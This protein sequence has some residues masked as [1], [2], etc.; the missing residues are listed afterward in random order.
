[1]GLYKYYSI[2][3]DRMGALWT[4]LS[5]RGACILEFGTAGTTRF[6]LNNF[7]KMKGVQNGQLYT[8]HLDENDIAMGDVSRMDKAIDDIVNEGLATNI[9]LM[10]STVSSV[11]GIDLEA[12]CYIY[13]EKYPQINFIYISNDGFKGEWTLGVKNTL[14]T[15]VD[16][17]PKEVNKSE[18]FTYNI[19]GACA[20]DYNYEVDCME[21]DRIMKDGFNGENVCTLTSNTSIKEIENMGAAHLNIVMRSEGEEAAKVLE[22]NFG[23]P[24]VMGR[25]YGLKGTFEWIKKIEKEAKISIKKEFV[26][27]EEKL[28]KEKIDE[29][30]L[31]LKNKS[32][33]L[34]GHYDVVI[35]I[36]DFMR[37]E[38][39]ININNIWCSSPSLSTE[40]VPF[41]EEKI[42]EEIILK[43]DYDILM[44]NGVVTNIGKENCKKLQI[45]LPNLVYS[46]GEQDDNP[47]VGF[48]GALCILNKLIK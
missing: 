25:P 13:R 11:I 30:S 3:S 40:E 19:I 42:W 23:T 28:L 10:S 17:I 9:F 39:G 48:K 33:C 36:R 32:I 44:G 37:D 14:E 20:D 43:G 21:V 34:S 6:A 22:R 16:N 35:G 26:E 5:I 24:Y 7:H 4:L 27:N 2:P 29:A 46:R 15:L 12:Y 31:V 1:M 45:D 47:Y 41:Y 8:T 38:I 18:N